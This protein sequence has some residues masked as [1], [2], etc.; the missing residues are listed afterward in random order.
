VKF[1]V[2]QKT[3]VYYN[4]GNLLLSAAAGSGKTASLTARI[5]RLILDG[6]AKLS[7]M[8]IVTYTRAAAAEMRARIRTKLADAAA[9]NRRTDPIRASRASEAL[10]ALPSAQISTIHSF[11]Y[12][13]MR[14][15]FASLGMPSDTRIMDT[16]TSKKMKSDVMRD[17]VDDFFRK[18]DRDGEAFVKLADVIGQARDTMAID[19]ELLWLAD[20]LVSFGMHEEGLVKYV[21]EYGKYGASD[22]AFFETEMGS[23]ITREL[24]EFTLHYYRIL[25]DIY[26][27]FT[28]YPKVMEKYGETL[29]YMIDWIGRLSHAVKAD[30]PDYEKV[31]AFIHEYEPPRLERLSS[32]DACHASDKFKFWRDRLKKDLASLKKNYFT[33]EENE[34]KYTSRATAEILVTATHVLGEYFERLR[35]AKRS[36]GVVDYSDLESMA[37]ELFASSDGPTAAAREVGSKFKYV[38]ID[39]YQDT[40]MVQDSIFSSITKDSVRFM[41]GDVK[42]SI[43]RFR[44]ADP[45]V[46]AYYRTKWPSL[47]K[48]EQIE[49]ETTVEAGESVDVGEG[50]RSLFMSDNFR[51][52]RAI[53]E[54]VNMI[55]AHTLARGAVPYEKEDELICSKNG[56]D[57]PLTP[58]E[59]IMIEKKRSSKKD[60]EDISDHTVSGNPEAAYVASRIASMIG[61]YSANGERIVSPSDIAII[62]RSPGNYA[63][64]YERELAAYGIPCYTKKS[65][66]LTESPSVMLIMCLLNFIDNPMRDIYAAGALHSAVFGFSLGEI[67]TLRDVAGDLPLYVALVKIARGDVE[68]V[69][70]ELYEK[71]VRADGVLTRMKTVAR[72]MAADRFLEFLIRDT[73]LYATPGIR[74]SGE[75][76]DA[77]SHLI[78]MARSFESSTS[79]GGI[80]GFIEYVAES[81][82]EE[83]SSAESGDAVQI[84][85]IHSSKGL[86]FPV[87]FL[88]E[89]G[90]G[91]NTDDESGT[92]LFDDAVGLGMMLPDEGGLAKYDTVMRQTIAGGIK[93][94]SIAE[95]MRM[96]YVALTRAGEQLI[97][98]AKTSD[99][100]GEAVSAAFI[101]EVE[102]G[103]DARHAGRYLDW[104]MEAAARHGSADFYTVSS[105]SARDIFTGR[106]SNDLPGIESGEGERDLIGKDELCDRFAFVYPREHLARI[107]S[108]LTVSRL[109]PKILDDDGSWE[110]SLSFVEADPAAD[111]PRPS[112][113]LGEGA[114]ASGTER[115]SAT[116]VFMQFAD[117]D[118]LCTN[119][120]QAELERLISDGFISR[121]QAGLVN[122]R[123]IER[124]AQ[125]SLI[126]KMRRSPMVKREFRFNARMAATE[127]TD[128]AEMKEKL[129]TDGVRLT[130]Q[131]VVDCVFRDP[132]TGELVLVDYKT[133]HVTEEEWR[134]PALAAASFKNRHKNQLRY[135]REI[136]SRMFGENIA[137]AEIYSTVLGRVIE[138]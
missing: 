3:A 19:A 58:V 124:F 1:T 6:E 105:V 82:N 38:F 121:A 32:K 20:R 69:R 104:I 108:K 95:E 98:T 85:S 122:L 55:S 8:L 28:K 56:G 71:S 43:Y 125:S 118:R 88:T 109:Y 117:F 34:I 13:E 49:D 83:S 79:F 42:Q 115:G 102:G 93:S 72:G 78:D 103:Y 9:E 16:G 26:E 11:L 51:C 17:V 57:T 27:E 131:G 59:V 80:S 64:S 132:D 138:V 101:A 29:S 62:M 52:D 39:E 136:C 5:V 14:P 66:K 133:D 21:L 73:N 100:D 92:I 76:R 2:P 63:V 90:K 24:Y 18:T 94:A 30:V 130:V 75:E 77:I 12:H 33:A 74:A 128:D 135:Y 25:V 99:A 67:V 23:V 107:P 129:A 44:K 36:R 84:M 114:T 61:K 31:R 127:F 54:F 91:R 123:Q 96:L 46:F 111:A 87:V 126:D 40:N 7:E 116:H 48:W 113:M 112:F 47:E 15:Y 120:A 22:K 4:K 50:G 81:E 41:V 110:E 106:R 53:I 37:L 60:D 35:A 45:R 65:G 70:G 137:R 10:S 134:D 86:E 119:G 97:V 68:D 89:C